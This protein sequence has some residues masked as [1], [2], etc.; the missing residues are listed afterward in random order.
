LVAEAIIF[1]YEST[2]AHNFSLVHCN[3]ELFSLQLCSSKH[4]RLLQAKKIRTILTIFGLRLE[5][6]V[7]S[8]A[9]ASVLAFGMVLCAD[10][11]TEERS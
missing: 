4:V 6:M 7:E 1:F 3:L 10:K 9:I 2:I 5:D 8:S 11:N